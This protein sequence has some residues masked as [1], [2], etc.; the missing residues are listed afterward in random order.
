[1]NNWS[2]MWC[3]VGR[4]ARR[5]CLSGALVSALGMPALPQL[6]AQESGVIRG[7]VVSAGSRAPV[8]EAEVFIEGSPRRTLTRGDGGFVIVGLSPGSHIVIAER[9]GFGTR[10]QR[11]AVQPG[12][13][14]EVTLRLED[15]AISIPE[16]VV[17]ASRSAKDL[18][19]VAASVGVVGRA[20]LREAQAGHPAEVMGQVPGVYVNVTGGEGHMT[21]IRQPL[22]TS[23]VYLYLEDGVP[24]RSTG[25]FNHNALYEVNLPQADR[26]E[27]MKGPANA[28]YGSD[29]IGGV[30]NVGTRAPTDELSGELSVEGGEHGF[31]RYLGSVS[32]SPGENG[33]RADFN[34]SRTDGW[35]A[36]TGYDRYSATL[37]WDRSLGAGTSVKT[38]IAYS[39]IDQNTAGSSAI[40][41]TDFER[42]PEINYAPISF[43]RVS[44]LRV[45]SALDGMSGG[46]AW[47]L[48]PFARMSSMDML[49]NWSLTYDP[50]ISRTEHA[51]LGLLATI[52]YDAPAAE[53][54]ITAGADVEHSPGSRFERLVV[55]ERIGSVFTDY[56]S[57][58][59]IYDYD[60]TFRGVS[61]YVHAEAMPMSRLHVSAGLRLDLLG[62]DYRSRLPAV[63]TGAHRRPAD[64]SPTF[65]AL[66]PKLG[67]TFEAG[68]ALDLFAAFRRGFR[69][70]SE[71]QLFRQGS[72]TNTIGLEPVTADS[73]EVG[74]RGGRGALSYEVSAYRMSKRDDILDFRRPDG[75]TEA[76]N[77]GRTLHEGVE[78]ALGVQ[79]ARGLRLDAAYSFAKHTYGDWR[80]D[81]TTS[82]SGNEQEFAPDQIGNVRLRLAPPAI[83]G[84]ILTA[85]WSRIGSYWMDAANEHEYE[86]HDLLHVR[87]SYAVN[88]HFDLFGRVTNVTGAR[89]AERATYSAFRGQELAPGLP[90]TLY[91]G[92]RVR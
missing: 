59:A 77:A 60:V 91:L 23:P 85:E 21:A 80:P 55:P 64:G 33:L 41:R 25:F 8:A 71:G 75:S 35:R 31:R 90:R 61:P 57:G 89:Y 37:R 62:Y 34:L 9:M 51:S 27:V 22:S 53:A 5:A 19:E 56:D 12:R 82:F 1:M 6:G 44:A 43:R 47:S 74:L 87:F 76:T 67:A 84:A 48:T 79:V 39:D 3:T 2:R 17:I 58:P 88:E 86:G 11:V 28:M 72:A 83:S 18:G 46:W 78:L 20:A 66:S 14:T 29:A 63:M 4:T 13:V 15:A 30:I 36:G 52:R 40:S 32:G 10:R 24:I 26:V 54:S 49:P 38:V 69:A 68:R 70:P 45:S 65:S 92:A 73:W 50:A 7:R 81:G 42:N 16:V